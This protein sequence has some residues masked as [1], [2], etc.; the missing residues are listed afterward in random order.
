MMSSEVPNLHNQG[1][2]SAVMFSFHSISCPETQSHKS[3][4]PGWRHWGP[5][6]PLCLQGAAVRPSISSLTR[7]TLMTLS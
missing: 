5:K 3:R 2:I 6:H 1:E 7:G 4:L